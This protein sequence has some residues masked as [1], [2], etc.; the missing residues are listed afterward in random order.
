MSAAI[1]YY[2]DENIPNIFKIAD[3]YVNKS[4]EKEE[5]SKILQ[6]PKRKKDPHLKKEKKNFQKQKNHENK[7]VHKH[8]E[9]EQVSIDEIK[10]EIINLLYIKDEF[11]DKLKRLNINT[12]KGYR[13]SVEII[14]ILKEIDNELETL[15]NKYRLSIETLK[16]KS[17]WGRFKSRVKRKANYQFKKI[18][19]IWKRNK[20]MFVGIAS[21]IIPAIGSLILKKI[22]KT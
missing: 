1:N 22:T 2:L 7:K 4:E 9:Q 16:R 15:S 21:V 8:M 5:K 19:K 18:K 20:E 13:K 6:M 17:G 12:K 11:K 3:E 10:N 14:R